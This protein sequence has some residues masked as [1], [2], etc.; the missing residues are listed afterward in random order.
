MMVGFGFGAERVDSQMDKALKTVM[1]VGKQHWHTNFFKTQ[2]TS[3]SK[4]LSARDT[5]ADP[6]GT[7]MQWLK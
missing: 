1:N 7:L 5:Q 6:E 2:Y 3:K 4:G